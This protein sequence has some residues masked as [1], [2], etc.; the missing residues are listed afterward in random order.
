[1]SAAERAAAVA[2]LKTEFAL[3]ES[4]LSPAEAAAYKEILEALS[5]SASAAP[6]T[7]SKRIVAARKLSAKRRAKEFADFAHV[8]E[9][10]ASARAPGAG[11]N[12][13]APPGARAPGGLST[14]IVETFSIG[15]AILFE[16]AETDVTLD[17]NYIL[18]EVRHLGDGTEKGP[19]TEAEFKDFGPLFTSGAIKLR[20]TS[21]GFLRLR[22]NT[23]MRFASG[24]ALADRI[25][26]LIKNKK[27]ELPVWAGAQFT[28][29]RFGG[30]DNAFV[31]ARLMLTANQF[32]GGG[33]VTAGNAQDIALVIAARAAFTGNV[34]ADYTYVR[35]FSHQAVQAGNL[36]LT[37]GPAIP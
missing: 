9:P 3:A 10:A 7:L 35:H 34:S 27:G 31:S 11:T 16:D 2:K 29:N 23:V 36:G 18:G 13:A 30:L 28:D 5:D 17:D 4:R 21:L 8:S 19:L 22:G 25:R 33:S 24:D 20:P 37:F 32:A 1:M 15:V 14:T 6:D 26:E 12:F